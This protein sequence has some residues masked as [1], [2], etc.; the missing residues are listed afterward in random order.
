MAFP[1]PT[2]EST[3][4]REVHHE[5]ERGFEARFIV[6]NLGGYIDYGLRWLCHI[7]TRAIEL[8]GIGVATIGIAILILIDWIFGD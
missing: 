8:L 6:D 5:C 1:S 3:S 2:L 7:A 4:Q